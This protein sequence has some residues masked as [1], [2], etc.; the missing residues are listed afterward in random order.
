MAGL[1]PECPVQDPSNPSAAREPIGADR[2]VLGAG[3]PLGSGLSRVM[4]DLL[5]HADSW[6][7]FPMSDVGVHES[8]KAMKKGRAVLRAVRPVLADDAYDIL[9][10]DLRDG[11]RVLSPARDAAVMIDLFALMAGGN[12]DPE[13][14]AIETRLAGNLD[15]QRSLLSAEVID[16]IR[17]RLTDVSRRLDEES[18]TRL[19]SEGGI[20]ALLPGITKV[21]RSAQRRMHRT[22]EDQTMV[23]F[24][25]WRKQ[26]KYLRYV[27]EVLRDAW[28]GAGD[29]DNFP[30]KELAESLGEEHDLAVLA[31]LI[32]D[33]APGEW[34][35]GVLA[36]IVDLRSQVQSYVVELGEQLLGRSPEDLAGSIADGWR[37]WRSLHPAE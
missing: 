25:E 28:P 20:D 32:Y 14:T 7:E 15:R 1:P 10:A 18:L 30:L 31:G 23:A 36:S 17:R 34:A 8:R 11:A 22:V 16:G 21:Y 5:E 33:H 27:A 4:R 2:F 35:S 9:N 29:P 37:S 13:R 26:V 3:E 12:S 24:H 19:D 6:L